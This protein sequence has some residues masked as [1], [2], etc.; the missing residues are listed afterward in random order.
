MRTRW[1]DDDPDPNPPRVGTT[2]IAK[3]RPWVYYLVST[4]FVD[5]SSHLAH[6]MSSIETGIP[7]DRAP[8]QRATYVTQVV[9]CSRL[10]VAK[11]WDRPLHEAQY[12]TLDAARIGH[13]RAVALFAGDQRR[14]AFHRARR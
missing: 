8:N 10:G 1:I 13:K 7:F 3:W 9:R 2:V 11:S 4:I 6:L 14:K 12:E 5:G